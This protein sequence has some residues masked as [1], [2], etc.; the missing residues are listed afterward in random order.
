[1]EDCAR[2]EI[3]TKSTTNKTPTIRMHMAAL[4]RKRR[5][6]LA[7]WLVNNDFL[8]LSHGEFIDCR[9]VI[10]LPRIQDHRGK[11]R[12]IRGIRKMLRLEAERAA[13]L[14]GNSALSVHRAVEKISRIKLH[15]RFGGPDFH[16]A[17]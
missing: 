1:M 9:R 14:V 17:A 2:A 8:H 4:P 10:L 13:L 7:R 12:L 16:H 6:L 5:F 15:A 11:F 3:V